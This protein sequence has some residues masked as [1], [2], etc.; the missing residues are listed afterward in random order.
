MKPEKEV[1]FISTLFKEKFNN[2][3]SSNFKGFKKDFTKILKTSKGDTEF[4]KW[5]KKLIE[6]KII[7]FVEYKKNPKEAMIFWQL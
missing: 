1:E 5:F 6:K 3:F 4:E 7:S 2:I